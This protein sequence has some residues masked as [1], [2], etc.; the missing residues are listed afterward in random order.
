MLF[1]LTVKYYLWLEEEM[2]LQELEK[3]YNRVISKHEKGHKKYTIWNLINLIITCCVPLIGILALGLIDIF[4][5]TNI[6]EKSPIPVPL[7]ISLFPLLTVLIH[8]ILKK[9][10]ILNE[11]QIDNIYKDYRPF[12]DKY[13]SINSID[14]LIEMVDSELNTQSKNYI[15]NLVIAGTL[16][17]AIWQTIVKEAFAQNM[18]TIIMGFILLCS[19]LLIT[20]IIKGANNLIQIFLFRISNTRYDSLEMIAYFLRE[21]RFEITNDTK[22]AKILLLNEEEN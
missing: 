3:E 4:F 5:Q 19:A 7:I 11:K 13:V 8:Y 10:M 21:F 20:V 12:L 1:Y 15:T 9:K 2:I 22:K 6:V 18:P 17:L 16:S 14:H